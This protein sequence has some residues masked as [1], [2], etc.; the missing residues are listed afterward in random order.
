MKLGMFVRPSGHHIASWRHPRAAADANVNFQ[1]YVEM[2]QIAE[3]GLFDML[4]SADQHTIW[5]VSEPQV[6][7]VHYSTWFEPVALFSA[8]SA[9]TKNIGLVSTASTTFEQPY[10]VARRFATLDLISGGRAGWN[11]VTSSNETE[12][13]NYGVQPHLERA[14]RYE[15]SQEFVEVVRGLW[16]SWDE[17]AFIRDRESGIYMDRSK[18][19]E[20]NHHGEHFNV[21]GPL[22]V[23]RSPQGQ[24]VIVQAGASGEGRELAAKTAEVVFTAT[25]SIEMGREFYSDVKGRMARYDR[26]PDDMKIMPGLLIFVAPT[27]AEAEAKYQTLQDLLHPELGIALLSRRIAAG[28]SAEQQRQPFRNGQGLERKGGA[29][30]A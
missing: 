11:V 12:A 10:S 23:A 21:R 24:P 13:Q 6:H 17:G 7:R 1:H 9:Y 30:I 25:D 19:H 2:A 22:N 18:M 8:L 5:T 3:R 28:A 16:D 26:Q 14:K 4:F 29:D 20:L 27:R 15:R